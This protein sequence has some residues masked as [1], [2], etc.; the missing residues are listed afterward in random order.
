MNEVQQEYYRIY[1][2]DT[3]LDVHV[4]NDKVIAMDVLQHETIVLL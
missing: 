4:E 1:L 3:L 2:L